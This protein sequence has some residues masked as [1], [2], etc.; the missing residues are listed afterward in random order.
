[1]F[2]E[3]LKRS[4][5]RNKLTIVEENMQDFGNYVRWHFCVENETKICRWCIETFNPGVVACLRI[6]DKIFPDTPFKMTTIFPKKIRE[7]IEIMTKK[8]AESP[9]NEP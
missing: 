2:Y 5:E 3:S 7:V 6:E 1:M 8:E 9:A 4:L